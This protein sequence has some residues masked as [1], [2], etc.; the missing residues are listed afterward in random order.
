MSIFATFP[1]PPFYDS[2][3]CCCVFLPWGFSQSLSISSLVWNDHKAIWCVHL[4]IFVVPVRFGQ[5]N[6]QLWIVN[7]VLCEMTVRSSMSA[8]TSTSSSSSPSSSQSSV[9][10]CSCYC[11]SSPQGDHANSTAQ[12]ILALD[13]HHRHLHDDSQISWEFF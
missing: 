1:Q 2:C 9:W 10:W 6:T 5:T 11:A 13:H 4:T 3:F 8:S 7:N 12:H